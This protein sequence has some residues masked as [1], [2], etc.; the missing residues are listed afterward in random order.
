MRRGIGVRE[1]VSCQIIFPFQPAAKND[2]TPSS[3]LFLTAGASV[4]D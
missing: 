4:D 2:L 1:L 3:H